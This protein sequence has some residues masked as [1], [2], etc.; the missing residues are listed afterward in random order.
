MDGYSD[1]VGQLG[2]WVGEMALVWQV[3]TPA[4]ELIPATASELHAIEVLLD[5]LVVVD[6]GGFPLDY[7]T[8]RSSFS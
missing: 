8:S 7:N 1:L 4:S 3:G 5:E 2:A 6:R